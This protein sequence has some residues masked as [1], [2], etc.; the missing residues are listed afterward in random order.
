[1]RRLLAGVVLCIT[2]FWPVSPLL[3][4]AS[5]A[6]QLPLCCRANGKHKCAL[7]KLHQQAGPVL[8][9]MCGEWPLLLPVGS[10]AVGSSV[11]LPAAAQQFFA[12]ITNHP[13]AQAQTESH[14]RVS[15]ERS[16]QKRGPP[17]S[18]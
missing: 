5:P 2:A 11:F 12:A 17:V 14:F 3:S 13:V 9:S 1:M 18:L 15:F 8:Q 16:R 10:T 6:P 7:S 4:S